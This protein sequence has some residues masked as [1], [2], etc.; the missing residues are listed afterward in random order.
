VGEDAIVSLEH[1]LVLLHRFDVIWVDICAVTSQDVF[2]FGNT[3]L[4]VEYL[5]VKDAWLRFSRVDVWTTSNDI[6]LH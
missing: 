1:I 4:S 5:S 2:N 3:L 6:F